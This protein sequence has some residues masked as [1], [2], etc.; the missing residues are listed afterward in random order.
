M[1]TLVLNGG[2]SSL[3]AV[4]CDVDGG[5][6]ALRPPPPLWQAR[7]DWGRRTA[8]AEI[9]IQTPKGE[10]RREMEVADPETVLRPVLESLWSGDAKAVGRPQD[11]DVVG[12]RIVHG[13]KAFRESAR[14]TPDVKAQIRRYVQFAPEHNRLELE[15]IE[16]AEKILGSDMPQVAVF[17]T[18][19]HATLSPAASTYPGPKDWIGEGIYRY[20]FHGISHQYTSRRAAEVL[21]RPIESLRMITCHLGN[22]ASLAAVAGGKSVDTTMGFTPLEGLMMGTRSGTID[23]GIIIHLVRNCGYRADELDRVLNKKSG[24]AG[25]SGIS[26]DMREVEDAMDSGNED[27]RLAFEV[28]VHR[29]CREIGGMLA[30][31][32]GMDAL[33]FTA[34]V[35][36]NDARLRRIVCERLAFLGIDLDAARNE[37]SPVDADIAASGS[38]VRALVVRTEEDWEIARECYRLLNTRSNPL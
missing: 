17:D 19:F 18:A 25:L 29:L 9:R 30:S 20:G 34:G 3:K 37:A 7:V 26:G 8:P 14:I 24:L 13:G 12:H 33:V 22:G 38:K 27:A 2:S 21:G 5:S 35:G 31:L 11:I 36:E 10:R 16:A 6:V 1:R 32:G 23:P 28:Y 4:L 15:G